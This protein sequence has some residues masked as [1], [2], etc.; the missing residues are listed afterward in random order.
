MSV[1]IELPAF[2]PSTMHTVAPAIEAEVPLLVT[3]PLNEN[4]LILDGLGDGEG[5]GGVPLLPPQADAKATV[6]R[7]TIQRHLPIGTSLFT[8]VVPSQRE[9]CL[10]GAREQ[11]TEGAQG[12]LQ[13][14][15]H[16]TGCDILRVLWNPDGTGKSS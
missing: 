4:I 7:N 6:M 3:F 8:G 12:L 11:G 15:R 2:G 5:D 13:R 9:R 16:R 1:V 14:C 10:D